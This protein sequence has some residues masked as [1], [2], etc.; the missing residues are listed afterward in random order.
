[1]QSK[2]VARVHF[3][4][5]SCRAFAIDENLSVEQLRAIVVEKI[6]LVEDGCFALFEK[7]DDWGTVYCFVFVPSYFLLTSGQRGA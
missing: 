7:R 6:G 3:V 5:E 4:D 1:M 2:R